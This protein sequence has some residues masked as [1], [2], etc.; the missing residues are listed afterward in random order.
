M[1]RMT[2]EHRKNLSKAMNKWWARRGGLSPEQRQQMSM[3]I[4]TALA[5]KRASGA[6]N[7]HSYKN[8][9]N[10]TSSDMGVSVPLPDRKL[11]DFAV[12]RTGGTNE[13]LWH[14]LVLSPSEC[15]FAVICG[16]GCFCRHPDAAKFE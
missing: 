15:E 9:F 7:G 16:G 14:C 1:S 4:K 2:D 12:C 13:N 8:E 6:S 5:R 10:T 11:P 3:S